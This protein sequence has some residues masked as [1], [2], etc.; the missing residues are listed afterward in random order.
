MADLRVVIG[1]LAV[2]AAFSGV[3]NAEAADAWTCTWHLIGGD[4]E[5][6]RFEVA[7]PDLIQAKGPENV[8]PHTPPGTHYRILQNNDY[9]LVATYS[10]SG[11]YDLSGSVGA[12]DRPY[13]G[14]ISVVIN[15]T[16]GEFLWAEAWAYAPKNEHTDDDVLRSMSMFLHGK[17]LH[18]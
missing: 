1:A 14:E 4:D 17:C 8:I 7:T 11:I 12:V 10:A 2:C 13:S 3:S 9:G 6:V 18:D 5:F 16:T 15:K